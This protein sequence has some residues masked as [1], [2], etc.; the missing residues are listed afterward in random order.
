MSLQSILKSITAL[1]ADIALIESVRQRTDEIGEIDRRCRPDGPAWI[2]GNFCWLHCEV[3]RLADEL[4]QN[5]SQAGAEALNSAICRLRDA[6]ASIEPIAASLRHAAARITGELV[7]TVGRIFDAAAEK[8]A[9]EIKSR[10]DQ[11][12]T[13]GTAIFDVQ[14]EIAAFDSRSAALVAQLEAE[15]QSATA[16]PLAWLVGNGIGVPEV[17]P[18]PPPAPAPPAKSFRGR[19]PLK[20][21]PEPAPVADVLSELAD[22]DDDDNADPFDLLAGDN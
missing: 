2:N 8:L 21:E 11:L 20:P 17:A 14:A 18:E 7:P 9:V 19:V 22:D 15:R 5:P 6:P 13:G 1:P 4:A 10:R 3:D 12:V 16:S